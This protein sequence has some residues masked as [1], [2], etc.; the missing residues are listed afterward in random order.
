MSDHKEDFKDTSSFI[1]LA[2]ILLAM[3]AMPLLPMLMG[4]FTMLR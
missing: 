1:H 4:W 2:M 3:V